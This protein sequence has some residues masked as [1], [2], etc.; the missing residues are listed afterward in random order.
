MDELT[1]ER[2][3]APP[4]REMPRRPTGP[5]VNRWGDTAW[6]QMRRRRE[7]LDAVTGWRDDEDTA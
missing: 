1:A 5:V 6:D 7:L 3:D 4:V 2:F